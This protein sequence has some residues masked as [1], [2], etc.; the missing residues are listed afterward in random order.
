[1]EATK[2]T[3][4]W[5]AK[6]ISKLVVDIVCWIFFAFALV[7]TVFAFSAQASKTNVP[8]IGNKALLN[9]QTDSMIGE[10]GF[11]PGDLIVIKVFPA[12]EETKKADERKEFIA[13]LK[14]GD[15]V[16]YWIDLNNDGVR[17]LNSHRIVEVNTIGG[18]TAFTTKG[19]NNPA[20]DTNAVF[21]TD[22][23]G[24]W[25]GKKAAGMGSFIDFLQPPHIGFFVFIIVPLAGFLAYEVVVLVLTIKKMKDGDK[26][27]I[28][29]ADEELIKQKAIEE[30]LKKQEAEKEASKENSEK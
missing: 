17:E 25:T 4:K 30:Y 28:S 22:V 24:V 7:F 1:M 29:K 20:N 12:I 2:E 8:T 9:V 23:V 11:K 26:R 13:D 21:D 3:K 14:E 19:D 18:Q 5:N 27:S 10:D 15:V 6:R 16:T